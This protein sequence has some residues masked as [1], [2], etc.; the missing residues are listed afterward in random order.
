MLRN[1]LVKFAQPSPA[2]ASL[3]GPSVQPQ[4][5]N[6]VT[7]PS[8]MLFQDTH[9]CSVSPPGMHVSSDLKEKKLVRGYVV[10]S[11]HGSSHN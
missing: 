8:G 9:F 11:I 1:V 7:V 10:V 5:G 4:T 2:V 6:P 3:G